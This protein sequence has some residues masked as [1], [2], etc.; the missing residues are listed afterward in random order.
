MN[1]TSRYRF[2]EVLVESDGAVWL[3]PPPPFEYREFSDT[4]VHR[5]TEGETLR[6]VAARYYAM[7]ARPEQFAWVIADFQ[8]E[9]I[10]D[11]FLPLEPERDLFVPS[12]R[13]LE[14]LILAQSRV[15]AP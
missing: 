2:S 6:Q 5:V 3:G 14:E 4:R 13:V 10:R 1:A 9:P 11:P 8:P 7:R 12:L 15:E